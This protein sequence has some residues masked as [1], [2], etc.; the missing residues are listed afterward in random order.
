MRDLINCFLLGLL[1]LTAYA[2][3]TSRAAPS[4]ATSTKPKLVGHG[5]IRRP[6]YPRMLTSAQDIAKRIAA[7]DAAVAAGKNYDGEPLLMQDGYRVT[8]E[9]RNTAQNGIHAHPTDAEMF[10]IIERTGTLTLGGTQRKWSDVS[11]RDWKTPSRMAILGTTI[12][13]LLS[14]APLQLEAALDVAVGLVCAGFISM[15]RFPSQTDGCLIALRHRQSLPQLDGLDVLENCGQRQCNIGIAEP[16]VHFQ[17]R[18]LSRLH[19]FWVYADNAARHRA[20]AAVVAAD[21]SP[22]VRTGCL[23]RCAL[24]PKRAIPTAF[25]HLD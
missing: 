21:R 13:N 10:V 17:A 23:V 6:A 14:V 7:A 20:V 9:W 8:M 19:C 3:Q 2:Q 1:S 25:H 4:Q 12:M 24:C 18:R 22:L 11:V 15:S 16:F 5:P